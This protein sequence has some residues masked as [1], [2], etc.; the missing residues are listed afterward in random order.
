MD[1]L[2]PRPIT[3]VIDQ[4]DF[5]L[6]DAED[7]VRFKE[8]DLKGFLLKLDPEQEKV[9]DRGVKGPALIKGGPGSGKS[10][11]ELCIECGPFSVMPDSTGNRYRGCCSPPT[12][13]PSFAF[14]RRIASNNS[15]A[16]I[17][18]RSIKVQTADSRGHAASPAAAGRKRCTIAT[19]TGK[20]RTPWTR[21]VWALRPQPPTLSTVGRAGACSR[22]TLQRAFSSEPNSP[23]S[24]RAEG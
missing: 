3:E 18:D 24:S 2:F 10:T 11:V 16:R 5:V 12:R 17:F 9:A 22:Q 13:T 1:A 23:G 15:S 19:A 7:L 8:G 21:S 20:C 6:A 4:P 14:Q